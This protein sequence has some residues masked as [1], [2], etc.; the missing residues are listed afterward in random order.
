M[1]HEHWDEDEKRVVLSAKLGNYSK[2]RQPATSL[3]DSIDSWRWVAP[4]TLIGTTGYTE[5]SDVF[6]LGTIMWHFAHPKGY[7]MELGLGIQ[8]LISRFAMQRTVR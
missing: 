5:Q 7:E 4:E 3:T 8:R 1:I 6:S 2:C